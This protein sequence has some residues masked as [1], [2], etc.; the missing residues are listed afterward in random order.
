[1]ALHPT[2]PTQM[3]TEK[4]GG[5]VLRVL[6]NEKGITLL[7]VMVTAI[8]IVGTILS[9][10]IGI[11]YAEKQILRNYRDR[12]ATL[13]ASGELEWQYFHYTNYNGAFA[14][15]NNRPVVIDYLPKGKQLIGSMTVTVLPTA[16]SYGSLS[17][18]YYA[19]T[20]KVQWIEPGDD[21]VRNI[22]LRED[23]YR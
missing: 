20:A 4:Q 6:S 13:L 12:V 23:I 16:E 15:F 19:L 11:V 2:V 3:P 14:P 10:Y 22:I 17:L 8:V 1:M 7:E 21:K 5:R 9:I 18:P